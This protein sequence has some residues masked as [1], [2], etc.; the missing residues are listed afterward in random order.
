MIKSDHKGQNQFA[1]TSPEVIGFLPMAR[2][3]A[4]EAGK[5]V[6]QVAEETITQERKADHSLVT[7]ADHAA[8]DILRR[9]LLEA[10]PAHAV[11]S[12]ETGRE[13]NPSAEYVWLVDPLDGTRAY[14]KR[15]PGFSV[16]VG[17]LKNENPVLGIV[18]DPLGN[19]LYEAVRGLGCFHTGDGKS[20][21][22]K[23]SDRAEWT[24]MPVVTSTGFSEPLKNHLT[25]K[26][27]L[28]FVDPINSV[29]IKVGLMV[30]QVA[31]IYVNHHPVH[32]WDTCAPQVVLEEAGGMI[33]LWDGSP[34]TYRLGVEPVHAG[35][36]LAT[37]KKRHSEFLEILSQ[38]PKS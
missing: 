29:G 23:V 1:A 36:T 31:D 25:G 21:Q 33:T 37:N 17:L 35:P 2:R 26:L 16:M 30:R 4:L 11:F 38:A 7:N 13:G 5:R 32:Y 3:L 6:M 19:H 14:A 18:V 8:N 20:R 34:L 15:V 28:S 12:E 22:V 24:Q 10:F 27:P 9:G